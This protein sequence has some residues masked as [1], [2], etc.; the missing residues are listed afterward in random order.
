MIRTMS[1]TAA[2]LSALLLAACG[3]SDPAPAAPDGEASQ[4]VS[5][6]MQVSSPFAGE[7]AGGAD[8]QGEESAGAEAILAELGA[9]YTN[10]NLDR[11]RRLFRQCTSCH[12]LSEGGRHLIG[13]NLHGMFGRVVGT[14][15]GFGY[16]D[17][18]QEAD[19]TWSADELDQWLANP[20]SYLPGNRMSFAGYRNAD[21][22]RDVIAYLAVETHEE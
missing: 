8:P 6:H 22:R 18:L 12:T 20:N 9:P 13:P 2:A 21:D 14:A 10:A 4:D 17:A 5:E 11:G 3:G 19:V 15:D 16:S 1:T 7:A